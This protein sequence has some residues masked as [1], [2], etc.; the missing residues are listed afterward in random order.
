MKF[1]HLIAVLLPLLAGTV[2]AEEQAARSAS[3]PS[4]EGVT[5]AGP[6][7]TL[8]DLRGKSVVIIV[9]ATT[10]HS[11]VDWPAEFL[12]Q[13]KAAAKNRPVVILAIN[14]EKKGRPRPQL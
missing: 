7:V 6:A 13:L 10:Y 14:A 3:L 8:G 12:A 9:N 2:H 11:E 5:W 1:A 4:L